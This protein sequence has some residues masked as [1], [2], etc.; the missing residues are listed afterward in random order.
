MPFQP[1]LGEYESLIQQH[2]EQFTCALSHLQASVEQT[3]QDLRQ[4]EQSL[5]EAQ[6]QELAQLHRQLGV[7][8]RCLLNS[9]ELE[10]FISQV[11]TA[12]SRVR[13]NQT[14]P[15][16][17]VDANPAHWQLTQMDLPLAIRDY[18]TTVDHDAYDDERTH[19][20]YGYGVT[21][22]IGEQSQRIEV[23]TQRIYSPIESRSY[24]LRQ[25]LDYYI[26]DQVTRLLSQQN[27][28]FVQDVLVQEISYLFGCAAYLLSL[29]PRTVEFH[30]SS[31]EVNSQTIAE[32]D[33]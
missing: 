7:D 33:P 16:P 26:E 28:A 30:Y 19:S 9:T 12:P 27:I 11:Q 29:T 18:E 22:L 14:Q 6:A 23:L 31:T 32:G 10:T 1:L 17:E 8:A 4:Q 2:Y 3:L 24:S 15:P 21:L 13:W 5:V 25:Q 20:A